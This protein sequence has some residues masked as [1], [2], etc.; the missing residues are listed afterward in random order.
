MP[1]VL[2]VLL[3]LVAAALYM[4]QGE[5]EEVAQDLV[6]LEAVALI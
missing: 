3:L 5:E 1:T 6:E 2:Q 4:E